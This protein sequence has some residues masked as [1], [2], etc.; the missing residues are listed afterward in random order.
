MRFDMIALGVAASLSV[1]AALAEAPTQWRVSTNLI[2]GNT[3]C[4]H[5]GTIGWV[6]ESDGKLSFFDMGN[7]VEFWTISRAADGSAF[8]ETRGV[9]PNA[10]WGR[11]RYQIVVPAGSG[12]RAFSSS[13]LTSAC[14]YKHEP[15]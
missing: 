15:M 7:T 8:G 5:R 9:Y 2:S 6:R 14:K 11:L 10:A 13:D 1:Q 3:W 4:G 12:P